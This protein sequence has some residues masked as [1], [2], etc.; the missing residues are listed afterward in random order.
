MGHPMDAV[1]FPISRK[2][3]FPVFFA[4]RGID[5]NITKPHPYLSNVKGASQFKQC[6]VYLGLIRREYTYS[7]PQPYHINEE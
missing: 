5:E 6:S 1:I 4:D 3:L 7:D 2:L